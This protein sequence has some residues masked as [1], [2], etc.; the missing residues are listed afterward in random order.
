[1]GCKVYRGR[2]IVRVMNKPDCGDCPGKEI[3]DF[4]H[5]LLRNMSKRTSEELGNAIEVPDSN[6]YESVADV[7]EVH[8]GSPPPVPPSMDSIVISTMTVAA[9]KAELDVRGQV[10]HS[11]MK[12]AALASLLI[13]TI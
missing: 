7:E 2:G 11:N 4:Y 5:S 13:Q 6:F 9:L 8:E 12:Q 1:M 10:Y 3:A